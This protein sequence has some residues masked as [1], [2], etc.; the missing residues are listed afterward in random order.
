M[1]TTA[2]GKIWLA[3]MGMQER[4]KWAHED[5]LPPESE[6]DQIAAS[7]FARNK[8]ENEPEIGALSVPIRDVSGKIAATLSA[9]GMLNRFDDAMAETALPKL[10]AAAGDLAA[11]LRASE[12]RA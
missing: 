12:V 4:L 11:E 5:E 1:A 9:F 10:K 2:Q 7:G 3:A 8:G 6:L